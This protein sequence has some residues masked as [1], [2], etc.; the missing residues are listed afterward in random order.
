MR[1]ALSH[2][3]S[4]QACEKDV[5]RLASI[6]ASDDEISEALGISLTEVRSKWRSIR[7]GVRPLSRGEAVERFR[8]E[9]LEEGQKIATLLVQGCEGK[10]AS[11]WEDL[12]LAIFN[13]I[14]P[15]IKHSDHFADAHYRQ[16]IGATRQ[17]GGLSPEAWQDPCSLLV[18]SLPA[19]RA[20]QRVAAFFENPQSRMAL[21]HEISHSYGI[22]G[23]S[24]ERLLKRV[25]LSA[26]RH[27]T[28][29]DLTAFV[30]FSE[31][32]C[33]IAELD[34]FC[35]VEAYPLLTHRL[36]TRPFS[37]SY[38][39]MKEELAIIQPDIRLLPDS[40][41][42]EFSTLA[43]CGIRSVYCWPISST[44]HPVTQMLVFAYRKPTLIGPQKLA[45]HK[46]LAETWKESLMGIGA[47]A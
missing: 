6:G 47:P 2:S 19:E 46:V 40:A 12:N 29:T 7:D 28:D 9:R 35:L 43:R 25:L 33:T 36:C 42:S 17:R 27:L 21:L 30:E 8:L 41:V 37:W 18:G 3:S 16:S 13:A 20:C 23:L 4:T 39:R 5:L 38:G 10:G 15:H 44:A 22:D 31:K 34:F 11:S 14:P 32:G 24:A 26:S 45:A 1:H